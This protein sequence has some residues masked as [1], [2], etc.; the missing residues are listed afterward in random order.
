MRY[1]KPLY[2]RAGDA[3]DDVVLHG[4]A[5]ECGHV[6]FPMQSYGCEVC[7]RHGPALQPRTLSGRGRLVASATVHIHA[8][9]ARPTPFAV[10]EIALEQGPTIRTL[11]AEDAGEPAPGTPMR[12][13]LVWV[14]G[15]PGDDIVDLRFAPVEDAARGG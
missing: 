1:L 4:G 3:S 11:L 2:A 7:G 8:D 10:A 5:C 12:A 9:K 14:A 15:E 6:F 13:S